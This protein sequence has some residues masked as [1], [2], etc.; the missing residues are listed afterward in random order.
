MDRFKSW[1]ELAHANVDVVLAKVD[2]HDEDA[3]GHVREEEEG[4]HA[5]VLPTTATVPDGIRPA[6]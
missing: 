5:E 6:G 1:E 2:V 3:V 4:V